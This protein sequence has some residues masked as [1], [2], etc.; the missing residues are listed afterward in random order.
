MAAKKKKKTTKK[1]PPS[2]AA[3]AKTAPARKAKKK[4]A[5]KPVK[6][7]SRKAAKKSVKRKA[8]SRKPVKKAARKAVKKKKQIVGEGDYRAS[9]AFL[10]DESNF[11]AKNK[12]RIPAMARE[13]ERAL[14][15]P[16][17]DALRDA[18]ARAAGRSRDTF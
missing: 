8:A 4:A 12:S 1:K 16:E 6:K 5:K 9:R 15:G 13:A 17:G 3:K 18:E 2:R 10:K 7:T 11:V 14:D